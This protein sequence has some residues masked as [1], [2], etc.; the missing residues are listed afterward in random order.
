MPGEQIYLAFPSLFAFK[1][2]SSFLEIYICEYFFSSIWFGLVSIL[3]DIL[4]LNKKK[5]EIKKSWL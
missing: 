4:N 5:S 3:I 1:G 2:T